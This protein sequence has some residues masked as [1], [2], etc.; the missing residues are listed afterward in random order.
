[1]KPDT[2]IRKL[3]T[4]DVTYGILAAEQA[5]QFYKQIFEATPL[6]A[7]VRKERRKAKTG[8]V[9]KIAIGSRLL[10]AK[11]EGPTGDDGYRAAPTFGSIPYT[12]A[13]YKL[14]WEISEDT[15]H[16]NIEEEGF[17][18][19]VMG[20]MTTQ[21][22]LDLE[23]LHWNGDG[24]TGPF[25]ILNLGWWAQM[26]AGGHVVDASLTNGGVLCK[27]HFFQMKAA[28]P[29]KYKSNPRIRWCMNGTTADAWQQAV[30]NRATAAGDLALLGNAAQAPLGIDIVK[31]SSLADGRVALTD[32]LNLI[33]VYTWD[34]RIRKA[35]E[36]K[37][38]VMNDMRYYSIF[39]DDDPIIEELD[40]TAILT[41]CTL[42]L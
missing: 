36:G 2:A 20:L 8:E 5:K 15:I 10:R 13:R 22:G 17:E 4:G 26:V 31:V 29:E 27:D 6:S 7:M 33:V 16:D 3:V 41:N 42:P 12:C 40:A 14:P 37:E 24:A 21:L 1:M 38:A 9:D 39:L 30:S 11:V 25:L 32:P 19:T 35:A 28:L 18:D 34:V 23:D